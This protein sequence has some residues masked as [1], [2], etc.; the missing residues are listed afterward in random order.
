MTHDNHSEDDVIFYRNIELDFTEVKQFITFALNYHVISK[1]YTDF[2]LEKDNIPKRNDMF[3]HYENKMFYY[4]C[5]TE[6]VN[7]DA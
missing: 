6:F 1:A 4:E 7:H 5:V 2:S 3:L